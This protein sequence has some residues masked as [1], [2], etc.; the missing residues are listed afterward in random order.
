M[1]DFRSATKFN[2]IPVIGIVPESGSSAPSSPVDGQ[3][4][5]DTTNKLQK[6]WNATSSAWVVAELGAGTIVDSMVASGAAIAESKLSLATDA[7]A[8]TG[9]RRTIGTG[10]LQALAGNSS[11]NSIATA[12]SASADVTLNSHKLINVADPSS[13][14]SQ[15]AATA[16]W[17]TSQIQSYL[18]GLDWKASADLATAAALPSNTYSS[19][20]Q[21][22]TAT[23]NGA[24]TV[25]AVAV[26]VGMRILVKNE[27]TA[28]NNGLYSVTAAGG[29]GAAYILTRT[30]DANTSVKVS[31]G[32]TVPIDSGG[33][34]NG[35]TIWLLT[36]VETIVLDTTAL[37]FS[38]IAAGSSYAA[39]TGITL[40]G[41]VFSLTAPVTVALGGTNSATASGARTNLSAAG[42]FNSA[43]IGD[44]SSTSITVTHNLNNTVP[45]VQVWD[46]SGAN[47]VRVECDVTS[48][49]VNAISLSFA[50]APATNSIKCVVMG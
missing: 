19:G 50:T 15:D 34:A 38:Q 29:A 27:V 37:P 46:I 36:T 3:I 39:G 22:L 31:G 28:K 23:A 26:S 16:N 12:T 21:T 7:A 13:T 40:T 48:T 35:G 30:T 41:N 2:K 6:V 25:D 4:W 10:A 32:M 47:P 42:L 1:P 8:G 45:M 24:L 18:N 33:T 43:A 44:G 49:S 20:A 17:V 14:V 9:S 5:Y 11:L